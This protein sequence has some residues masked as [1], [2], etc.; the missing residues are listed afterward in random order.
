MRKASFLLTLAAACTHIP[1]DVEARAAPPPVVAP[2]QRRA[3][4]AG[5][6][7]GA[8]MSV[9]LRGALEAVGDHLVYVF[10]ED[11]RYTGA[12]ISTA[13]CAPLEG[14]YALET[15]AEGA[16]LR[17]DGDLLFR[18]AFVDDRL[19]LVSDGSYVLLRRMDRSSGRVPAGRTKPPDSPRDGVARLTARHH[20]ANAP[21]GTADVVVGPLGG[22]QPDATHRRT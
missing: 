11:G 22:N 14:S 8:W 2:A 13:E 9:E 7:V 4:L 10:A 1:P 16:A 18:A 20:A 17:L 3:P 21:C 6:L 12:A 5:E 19:E 15:D